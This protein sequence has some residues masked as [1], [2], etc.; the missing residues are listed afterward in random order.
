M[1]THPRVTCG[2]YINI[3][4]VDYV[5]VILN[6]NRTN[7]DWNLDPRAHVGTGVDDIPQGMQSLES[8]VVACELIFLQPSVTKS[9]W[10]SILST[11]GI[12]P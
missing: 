1:L 10:S 2:L 12:Q 7:S 8:Q 11:D 4:L 5:R 9:A 6:L 3:I